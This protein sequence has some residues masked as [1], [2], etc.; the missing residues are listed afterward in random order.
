MVEMSPLEPT[1]GIIPVLG[2]PSSLVSPAQLFIKLLFCAEVPREL[3]GGHPMRGE[4]PCSPGIKVSGG[5]CSK[6]GPKTHLEGC[7]FGAGR[8]SWSLAVSGAR[9]H[10]NT[11]AH[12]CMCPCGA[13]VGSLWLSC[14]CCLLGPQGHMGSLPTLV[15]SPVAHQLSLDS[16]KKGREGQPLLLL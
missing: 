9:T 4:G 6:S 2:Q 1:W 8:G 10:L 3:A 12:V 7:G 11:P 14:K 16:P 15:S 5:R 13:S